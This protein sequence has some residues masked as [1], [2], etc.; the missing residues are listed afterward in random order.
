[1]SAEKY[2][3]S[4]PAEQPLEYDEKA[5]ATSYA[6]LLQG[7]RQVDP[8][9]AHGLELAKGRDAAEHRPIWYGKED[10]NGDIGRGRTGSQQLGYLWEYYQSFSAG[11]R[12]QHGIQANGQAANDQERAGVAEY[13]A[14]ALCG[15]ADQARREGILYSAAEL[16][17]QQRDL[18]H[19]D[20]FRKHAETVSEVS[21]LDLQSSENWMAHGFKTDEFYCVSNWMNKVAYDYDGWRQSKESYQLPE[22]PKDKGQWEE[23]FRAERSTKSDYEAALENSYRQSVNAALPGRF[24]AQEPKPDWRNIDWETYSPNAEAKKTLAWKQL[25][26]PEAMSHFGEFVKG[27][28]HTE[29]LRLCEH[30][31]GECGTNDGNMYQGP[32]RAYGLAYANAHDPGWKEGESQ[33]AQA[34]QEAM[35]PKDQA[36]AK[37]LQSFLEGTLKETPSWA[38]GA[39]G[40]R[41]LMTT[42]SEVY[43]EFEREFQARVS[44]D[45]D[46]MTA[47]SWRIADSVVTPVENRDRELFNETGAE[48]PS[49]A[50]S[51]FHSVRDSIQSSLTMGYTDRLGECA[52]DL[53]QVSRSTREALVA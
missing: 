30:M 10:D 11:E 40:T 16:D 52:E 12:S 45:Y 23:E 18:L 36:L 44:T 25:D 42:L 3:S 24:E 4:Y 32:G 13:I 31:A 29:A 17:A 7:L 14:S 51:D 53:A 8:D 33:Y 2:P 28:H 43:G 19:P 37:E 47:M 39:Q 6:K 20:L 27:L 1:M 50:S 46:F 34:L 26:D 22:L 9:V 48:F 15:P 41:Q 35:F 49:T 38:D 5:T 21:K